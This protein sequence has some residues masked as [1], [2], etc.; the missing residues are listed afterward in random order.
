MS[1]LSTH[2]KTLVLIYLVQSYIFLFFIFFIFLLNVCNYM[3]MLS[4][5]LLLHAAVHEKLLWSSDDFVLPIDSTFHG[6]FII[7]VEFLDLKLCLLNVTC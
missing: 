3:R 7:D 1:Q 2:N 4:N 5:F 6:R